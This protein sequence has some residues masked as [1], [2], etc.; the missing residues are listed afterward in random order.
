MFPLTFP[1]SFPVAD[2]RYSSDRQA[3]S[4]TAAEIGSPVR[5]GDA[6]DLHGPANA[7]PGPAIFDHLTHFARLAFMAY[8]PGPARKSRLFLSLITV[9]VGL[10]RSQSL[11]RLGF[12]GV[13]D[14]LFHMVVT[15][16]V[17]GI[18]P[19]NVPGRRSR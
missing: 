18:V 17:P 15:C 5:Q 12:H 14:C 6:G 10:S 1:Q 2:I 11:G 9:T 16:C 7:C 8:E 3:I 19:A 4:G 13:S